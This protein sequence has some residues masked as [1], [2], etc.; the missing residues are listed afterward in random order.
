MEFRNITTFLKVAAT[1]NISKAAELLG[2]SQSAVTVQIQQLEKE[3]GTKLF[4]RIGKS[5]TLT[6]Q[7]KHFIVY[8][9]EIMKA[10]DLALNFAKD[11]TTPK[12]SLH[13]GAV[14]SIGTALLPDLLLEFYNHC[15]NVE[16]VVRTGKTEELME[17][18]KR[19]EIDLIF[20]LD[21]KVYGSEWICAGRSQE[22]IIFVS[23]SE[24]SLTHQ[25]C[26]DIHSLT[27]SPFILTETGASYRYELERKLSEFELEITPVLEIG[28]TETIIH[29]LEKGIGSSF[30]PY[31]TVCKKLRKG[32]L[33]QI[34][35]CLDEVHMYSQLLYHK[36]K[37]VT[38]QMKFF[39]QI[40]CEHFSSPY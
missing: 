2:Y 18:A 27:A 17:L 16:L 6:E 22:E 39:I 8:A 35:T 3:L 23:S 31:F 36:N 4:E 12:G 9:N 7:G 37:W 1:Q 10:T 19:N 20:T 24:N 32:I 21:Q 11:D 40:V 25:T 14:E 30:L 33:A 15:P 26:T 28:N 34:H 29:L 5:V 38:P 13:I